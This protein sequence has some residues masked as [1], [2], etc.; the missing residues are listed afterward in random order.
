MYL[1]LFNL[2][3]VLE[4]S[5]EANDDIEETDSARSLDAFSAFSVVNPNT[6]PKWNGS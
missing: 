5:E 1:S 6:H 2:S 4:D 3:L